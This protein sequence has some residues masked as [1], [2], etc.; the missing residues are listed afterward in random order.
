MSAE[1]HF[2]KLPVT[3][4]AEQ[5]ISTVVLNETNLPLETRI[6]RL[7]FN[8]LFVMTHRR[9]AAID[10]INYQQYINED[11]GPQSVTPYMPRIA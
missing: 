9:Q 10:N 7:A 2:F 11:E 3:T 1:H 8:E 4:S 5:P 6:G